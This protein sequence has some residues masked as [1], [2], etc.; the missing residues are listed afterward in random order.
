VRECSQCSYLLPPSWT[1]CKRCG[2][3]ALSAAAPP[4]V[5]PP[6]GPA[7][8]PA[9]P[10]GAQPV[11]TAAPPGPAY[12]PRYAAPARVG[13]DAPSGSVGW[14]QSPSTWSAP[15]KTKD[16]RWARPVAAVLAFV[17]VGI[18]Y[19]YWSTFRDAPPK[20]LSAYANGGGITY[21][22]P[23][24]GYSIRLPGTPDESDMSQTVDGIDLQVNAAIVDGRQWEAVVADYTLPGDVE[25][26]V[27][28]VNMREIVE[29]ELGNNPMLDGEIEDMTTTTLEGHPAIEVRL[30]MSDDHPFLIKVVF[31]AD[32][33]YMFGAH[34]VKGTEKVFEEMNE[35][36]ELTGAGF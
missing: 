2:A 22:P 15:V 27:T 20:E 6:P 30:E 29:E 36:F 18:G 33:M 24:A 4:P 16:N 12:D 13:F 21:E 25:A 1:A 23:G 7:P 9:A 11:T 35:S 3:P 32:K 31:V 5:A 10:W 19:G 14:S 28:D 26:A 8:A 34:A 17:L